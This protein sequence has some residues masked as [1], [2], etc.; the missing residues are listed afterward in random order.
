ML[1]CG[2]AILNVRVITYILFTFIWV[3]IFGE[4]SINMRHNFQTVISLE[5]NDEMGGAD[6]LGGGRLV[7]LEKSIKSF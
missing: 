1:T 2:P 7:P 6:V 4:K 3:Q 5:T